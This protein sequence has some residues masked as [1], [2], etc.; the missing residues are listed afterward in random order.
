[1]LKQAEIEM[2]SQIAIAP[3]NDTIYLQQPAQSPHMYEAPNHQD[4]SQLQLLQEEIPQ[5]VPV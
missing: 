1:M 5:A 2:N 4:F 3:S